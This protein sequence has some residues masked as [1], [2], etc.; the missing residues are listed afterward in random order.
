MLDVGQCDQQMM[1]KHEKFKEEM[2]CRKH[3][4]TAKLWM[5]YLDH[6]WLVLSLIKAVKS[7][8]YELY[9]YCLY[10]MADLFFSFDGQNYARYLTFFAVFLANIEVSHP[11]A[12]DLL[13]RGA[14]S[15]AR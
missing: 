15:A 8:D 7:N 4:K 12:T 6:V 13:K 14:F 1:D 9:C 2:R 11:G 5:S 10:H 3:G